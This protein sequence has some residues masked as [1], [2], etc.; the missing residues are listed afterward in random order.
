[1]KPV[2]NLLQS[3]LS[4]LD[5]LPPRTNA[6]NTSPLKGPTARES[7]PAPRSKAESDFLVFGYPS[8]LST[9]S[10]LETHITQKSVLVGIRLNTDCMQKK[11]VLYRQ[12]FL[13]V[14]ENLTWNSIHFHRTHGLTWV[15]VFSKGH[16][17][18]TEWNYLVVFCIYFNHIF[19]PNNEYMGATKYLLHFGG[20][21][22]AKKSSNPKHLLKSGSLK[23]QSGPT[24][25]ISVV[26]FCSEQG[27][28]FSTGHLH[29]PGEW[30]SLTDWS[31]G[32]CFNPVSI[33]FLAKDSSHSSVNLDSWTL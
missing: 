11:L 16:W 24:A 25:D 15:L 23:A 7:L 19:S 4:I 13:G 21:W 9:A 2:S 22:T 33:W 27:W 8:Q 20:T 32:L 3:Q 14:L 5:H 29:P 31:L 10:W 17:N 1:M 6:T 30:A 28:S 12:C 18:S 26:R